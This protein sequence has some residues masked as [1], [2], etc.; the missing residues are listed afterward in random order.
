MFLIAFIFFLPSSLSLSLS[1][2]RSLF[3]DFTLLATSLSLSLCVFFL[4]QTQD[5]NSMR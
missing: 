2:A 4:R 3:R 1:L 5:R